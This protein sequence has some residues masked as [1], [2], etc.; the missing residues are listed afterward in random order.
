ME[1]RDLP[2]VDTL[3]R[4]P[5]LSGYPEAVRTEA[6]RNAVAKL[7]ALVQSGANADASSASELAM[8][9]AE[10]LMASTML[11]V[12]NASGVVLHTGLGR[13]R[14]APSVVKRLQEVAASH[15][16]TE[17]D[18]DTGERGD[19]QDHV[20]GLL[21][22]LTDAEDAL[23]V[24]NCAAA[25]LL[26]LTALCKG[27]EVILSRGQM[28]EIGG[29]FRMPDIVRESGCRLVEVGC[30]NKTRPSDYADAVTEESAA[31]LR[32]HPSNY[33]IVGFTEEV[34]AAELRRT[35]TEKGI[36]LID[37]MGNGCLIDL[38]QFGLA[39]EP[40]LPEVVAQGADI[41]TA[42]A[43]KLLGGPQAGLI[44]GSKDMISRIK[45]HPLA[46]AMRVDKL[47]LC[48]LEETLRLY[49]TGRQMEIPTLAS[50]A[51]PLQK[52]KQDAQRL[53]SAFAGQALLAQGYTEVG[54]GSAPGVG[55][56]TWRVGLQAS[57]P[58][59]LAR[60]LRLGKP[61]ILPRIEKETVWLD[62]RTIERSELSRVIAALKEL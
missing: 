16:A 57:D 59:A 36:L 12:I 45:K 46:R 60:K 1:L 5:V 15:V 52:I 26:T 49:A 47:T 9:E 38:S 17:I 56:P 41:V 11:E 61:S 8:N 32:C 13:A 30:T 31:I 18:L 44:L 6:A 50:L 19:R 37:D 58:V 42:S 43:D 33:R 48:A 20:R 10:A 62:P 23:V 2:K 4:E 24:N 51:K 29:A 54:G 39:K 3:S 34:S 25:V 35:A 7:R 27:R 22:S 28:I 14:L 53:K 40:T 55:L 21:H